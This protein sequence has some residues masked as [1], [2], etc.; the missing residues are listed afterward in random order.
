[1]SGF[2][3]VFTASDRHKGV[4]GIV[5]RRQ[6]RTGVKE[7]IL[8]VSFQQCPRIHC[9]SCVPSSKRHVTTCE[10]KGV[11]AASRLDECCLT[12]ASGSSAV[13]GVNKKGCQGSTSRHQ[14]ACSHMRTV[15]TNRVDAQNLSAGTFSLCVTTCKVFHHVTTEL[16]HS[17]REQIDVY[18]HILIMNKNMEKIYK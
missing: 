2:D 11:A 16:R 12:A 7:P 10:R 6:G 3:R 4:L 8:I 13:Q 18:G 14:L 9:V 1:M 5:E 17:H 15:A